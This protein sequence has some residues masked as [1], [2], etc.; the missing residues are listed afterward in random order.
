MAEAEIPLFPRSLD[1]S[2][3]LPAVL[4]TVAA[5]AEVRAVTN[6]LALNQAYY[7]RNT[8]LVSA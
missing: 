7:R 6:S 1:H 3:S 2:R 5:V 8:R 4:L